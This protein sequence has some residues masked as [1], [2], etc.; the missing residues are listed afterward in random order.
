MTNN[1]FLSFLSTGLGIAAVH[2]QGTTQ[3]MELPGTSVNVIRGLR[4]ILCPEAPTVVALPV[5]DGHHADLEWVAPST[6]TP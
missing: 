3:G 5:A 1:D 2:F 6:R 4:S